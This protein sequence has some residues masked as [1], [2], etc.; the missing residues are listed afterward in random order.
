MARSKTDDV[1]ELTPAHKATRIS[2]QINK[3]DGCSATS[4]VRSS[5]TAARITE[6]YLEPTERI[7]THHGG[8]WEVKE[9]RPNG[10]YVV[11][12]NF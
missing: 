7:A 1:A 12:I 11:H 9:Q 3:K 8:D 2:E 10:Q 6:E 4:T 5:H